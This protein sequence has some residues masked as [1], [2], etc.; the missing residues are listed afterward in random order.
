M[1][2]RARI[3]GSAGLAAPR[4][5]PDA[6]DELGERERL[7]KVVVCAE[8]EPVDAVL[9]RVGGGQHQDAAAAALLDER[10]ADLVAVDLRQVAVEHDH[11]VALARHVTESVL[12]V[13]GDIDRHP[14]AAQADGDRGRELSV[15]LDD[16]HPHHALL[17]VSST[18]S[19]R[20]PAASKACRTAGYRPITAAVIGL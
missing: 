20:W 1:S 8:A 6:G 12:A 2:P 14:F 19:A 13:E 15:I 17:P 18:V 3:G 16:E 7:G 11:V 10:P 9:D 5:R 4:E